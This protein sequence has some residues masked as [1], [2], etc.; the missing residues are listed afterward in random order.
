MR[1]EMKS[2]VTGAIRRILGKDR[3]TRDTEGREQDERIWKM[4]GIL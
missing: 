4:D 3:R 1:G 2:F